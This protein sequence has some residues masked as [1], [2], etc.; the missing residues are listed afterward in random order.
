M[1]V[2]KQ[3]GVLLALSCALFSGA[4]VQAREFSALAQACRSDYKAFCSKVK[5]GTGEVAECLQQHEAEL[6]A[7]CKAQI[8][9]VKQCGEQIKSMCGAAG[10]DR[11]AIRK[12]MKEH[13]SEL[14]AACKAP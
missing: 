3:I 2:V 13:A 14:G 11:D 7:S 8:G 9:T 4:I 6:S 12:C 5:P 1:K 10:T